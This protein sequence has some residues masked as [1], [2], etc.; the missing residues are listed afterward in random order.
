[1][2]IGSRVVCTNDKFPPGV[3]LTYF[4]K[5][6]SIYTIRGVVLGVNHKGEEGEVAVYLKGHHNPKSNVPPFP[7]RGYNAERFREVEPPKTREET[8]EEEYADEKE[9]IEV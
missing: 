2:R 8:L 9:L 6:D 4:P 7:E 5:K 3:E 1:M